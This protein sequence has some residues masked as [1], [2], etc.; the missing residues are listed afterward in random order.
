[1][2]LCSFSVFRVN[3]SWMHPRQRPRPSPLLCCCVFVGLSWTLISLQATP[4][5]DLSPV[6]QQ[7]ANY[8]EVVAGL[9]SEW[10]HVQEE[11]KYSQRRVLLGKDVKCGWVLFWKNNGFEFQVLVH[12]LLM[13]SVLLVGCSSFSVKR[14]IPG[15]EETCRDAWHRS[16]RGPGWPAGY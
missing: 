5:P 2:G 6:S 14:I 11:F 3:N 16:N 9:F 10:Q 1:M 13:C 15:N 8:L 7:D 4:A 12:L